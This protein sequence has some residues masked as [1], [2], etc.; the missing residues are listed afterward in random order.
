[1]PEDLKQRELARRARKPIESFVFECAW[2]QIS[3]LV[4]PG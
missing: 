1:L 4:T 2:G 3:P